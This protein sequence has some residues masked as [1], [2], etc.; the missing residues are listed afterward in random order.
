MIFYT[1]AGFLPI[2]F[3]LL[4]LLAAEQIDGGFKPGVRPPSLWPLM[5]AAALLTYVLG[6]YLN[7]RGVRH[8]LYGHRMENVAFA[9]VAIN[10]LMALLMAFRR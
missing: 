9:I 7:R 6:R 3:F 10:V 8:T 5:G 1:G 4:A 2:A